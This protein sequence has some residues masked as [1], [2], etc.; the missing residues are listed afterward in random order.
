MI[1]TPIP[2]LGE[3]LAKLANLRA[4]GSISEDEF[5]SLKVKL[6]DE[7]IVAPL[8]ANPSGRSLPG[9][10]AEWPSVI[11]RAIGQTIYVTLLYPPV[12]ALILVAGFLVG[13]R[14]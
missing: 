12:P 1:S 3:Q 7:V 4:D 8:R 5:R 6:I 11:L 2:S 10:Q 14:P 13:M 9:T